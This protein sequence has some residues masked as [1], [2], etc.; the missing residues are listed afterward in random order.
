MNKAVLCIAGIVMLALTGC[1]LTAN[2]RDASMLFAKAASDIGDFSSGELNHFRTATIDM[3]SMDI[4]MG[5]KARPN[6]IDSAQNPEYIIPRVKAAQALGD[7]G[8]LLLMLVNDS[9][10]VELKQASDNFVNSF[11][12]L[13][14]ANKQL[15]DA[16][17]QGLGQAVQAIGSMWVEAEKA[18]VLKRIVPEVDK[19]I[20]KLCDLLNDDFTVSGL[21]LAADFDATIRRLKNDSEGVLDLPQPS[22]ADRQLAVD[23][24]KRALEEGDRLNRITKQAAVTVTS[25]KTAH[26]E[27][28]DALENDTPSKADITNLGQEINNLR[29]AVNALSRSH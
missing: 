15:N 18:K 11:K 21:N 17:L 26:T 4:A 5:G 1:A 24:I 29:T 25:I 3:N 2:Q 22:A 19:D 7:Y 16:Q 10:E 12:S 14:I 8:R 28:K 9:Q 27:L 13:K 23:G 6:N 20:G